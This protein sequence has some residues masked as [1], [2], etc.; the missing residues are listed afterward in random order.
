[1]HADIDDVASIGTAVYIKGNIWIKSLGLLALQAFF[2]HY[3]H[4]KYNFECI[5]VNAVER[6]RV[7]L[8]V[9]M[10]IASHATYTPDIMIP[11]AL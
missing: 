2:L 8:S 3:L 4:N 5:L 7:S 6:Q 1:M 9:T 10:I 11:F